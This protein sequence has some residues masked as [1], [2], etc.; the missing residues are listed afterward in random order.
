[1]VVVVMRFIFNPNAKEFIRVK[2]AGN[3][4]TADSATWAAWG[5]ERLAT[6]S[7]CMHDRKDESVGV[8]WDGCTKLTESKARTGL[9]NR[10]PHSH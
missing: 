2:Q 7:V 4:A 8:G 9:P 1:M 3:I 5:V 6:A 10:E